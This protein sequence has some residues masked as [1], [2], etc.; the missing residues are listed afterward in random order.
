MQQGLQG[1]DQDLP[2]GGGAEFTGT[3]EEARRTAFERLV[4]H[5]RDLGSDALVGLR[6]DPTDMGN[7]R[8]W[9]RSSRTARP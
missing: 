2:A 5:A 6:F 3:L 4:E 8:A 1:L 7:S 9:R